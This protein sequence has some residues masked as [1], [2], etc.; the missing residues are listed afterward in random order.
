MITFPIH[1]TGVQ[2]EIVLNAAFFAGFSSV[3]LLPKHLAGVA[4]YKALYPVLAEKKTTITQQNILVLDMSWSAMT[5]LVILNVSGNMIIQAMKYESNAGAR[6]IDLALVD[7]VNQDI[8]SRYRQDISG[9]PYIYPGY[10]VEA[11][12]RCQNDTFILFRNHPQ[13][14][15][16]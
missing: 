6:D 1:F 14:F 4:F 16:S 12:P 3:G 9:I 13:A 5:A 8:F 10:F 2:Q 15:C 11:L 7:F